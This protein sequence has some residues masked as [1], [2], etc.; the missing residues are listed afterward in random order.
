MPCVTKSNKYNVLREKLQYFS[1]NCIETLLF[2][3]IFLIN[4]GISN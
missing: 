4:S 3:N 1:S 2:K